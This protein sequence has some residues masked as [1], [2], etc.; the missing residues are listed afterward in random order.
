MSKRKL[1]PLARAVRGALKP[2]QEAAP[3]LAAVSSTEAMA[4]DIK[5]AAKLVGMSRSK[6]YVEFLNTGRVRPIKTGIRDRII[7]LPELRTAYAT[8]CA[9]RRAAESASSSTA[10]SAN[11]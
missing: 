5:T 7:D 9:E 3:V 1:K 2:T 10:E 11:A 4:T 8:Y 6:F